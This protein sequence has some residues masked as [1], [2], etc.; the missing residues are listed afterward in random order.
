MS[1]IRHACTR[2]AKA[3]LALPIQMGTH[4][5]QEDRRDLERLQHMMGRFMKRNGYEFASA[6]SSRIRAIELSKEEKEKRKPI[7]QSVY[8]RDT[9]QIL[10]GKLPTV[11]ERGYDAQII[12]ITDPMHT[13]TFEALSRLQQRLNSKVHLSPNGEGIQITVTVPLL[14]KIT[15]DIWD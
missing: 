8:V 11:I 7:E 12:L 10:F 3:I 5:S 2:I 4:Y 9:L 6:D 1:T 13:T 14:G 15:P